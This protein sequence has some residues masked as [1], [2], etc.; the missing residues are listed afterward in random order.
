MLILHGKIAMHSFYLPMWSS[1]VFSTVWS[2]GSDQLF[3][4]T[5]PMLP[6]QENA[7]TTNLFPF[8]DCF[9]FKFEEVSI[10]QLQGA[11]SSGIL[12]CISLINCHMNRFLQT[13]Q[14]IK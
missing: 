11:M 1:M 7:N 6:L 5:P 12:T 9:G 8:S 4:Y 2:T 10:N 14:Y 13:Q 3:D